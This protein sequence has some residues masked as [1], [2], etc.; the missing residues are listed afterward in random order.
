MADG[1]LG[2]NQV[3][4]QRVAYLLSP[5]LLASKR[6]GEE[7]L[8]VLL[9]VAHLYSRPFSNLWQLVA[10]QK[11]SSL[12]LVVLPEDAVHEGNVGKG[13][14]QA[15]KSMM[16]GLLNSHTKTPRLLFL[17]VLR[18]FEIMDDFP[19][20]SQLWNSCQS[21]SLACWDLMFFSVKE[22]KAAPTCKM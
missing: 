21:Y 13:E 5:N 19:L 1:H 12:C 10:L 22:D 9:H 8:S 3:S 16:K 17:E 7:I 2:I 18:W 11:C 15:N 4:Q 6:Q 20:G 14:A